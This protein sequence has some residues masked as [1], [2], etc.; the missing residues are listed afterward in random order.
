MVLT[1]P[2]SEEIKPLTV[3]GVIVGTPQ[4]MA[5]EQLFGEPVDG[6]A[7]LYAT[8]AVLFECI[9]GRRV[10]ETSDLVGLL[11]QHLKAEPPDP[12]SLNSD[13][14]PPLSRAIVRSLAR[15][16]E[17]RWPT[18]SDFLHALEQV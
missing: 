18:A 10:F 4:Y 8:G 1:T 15:K 5:P 6:R 13:I 14:P 2:Q 12:S 3:E 7:D 17:D 11:G 9:T 16:P